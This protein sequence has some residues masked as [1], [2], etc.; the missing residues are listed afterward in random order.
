MRCPACGFVSFPHLTTCKQCG[1]PLP[2]SAGGP[3]F[4]PPTPSAA[5]GPP[6]P[7]IGTTAR[8]EA[9]AFDLSAGL[10]PAG[11]WIRFVA[12]LVDGIILSIVTG[13]V[14]LVLGLSA[15]IPGNVTDPFAAVEALGRTF[16]AMVLASNIVSV[17]YSVVFVGWR[18]QTPGKILLRLKIIRVDGG[19][20][21]YVKAFIRWV[22]YFVSGVILGIGYIMAAFTADKRALHD[23]IAGTRVIRM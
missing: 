15:E 22:G 8:L 18:G 9:P 23:Y 13:A 20:V 3:R 7:R 19:E 10:R 14:S 11:F 17:L 6:P 12:F 21:D 5:A 4:T 16:A 2:A 1:K